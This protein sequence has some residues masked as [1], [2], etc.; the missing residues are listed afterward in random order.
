MKYKVIIG[1]ADKIVGEFEAESMP[2]VRTSLIVMNQYQ[3]SGEFLNWAL[4]LD[5]NKK[6]MATF[7]RTIKDSFWQEMDRSIL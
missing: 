1:R 2:D 4:V 6:Q 3:G 5:S 7:V